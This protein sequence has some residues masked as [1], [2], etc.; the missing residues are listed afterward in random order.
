MNSKR[1]PSAAPPHHR[2]LLLVVATCCNM[3][4]A[5]EHLKQ[6]FVHHHQMLL[7]RSPLQPLLLKCELKVR[8]DALPRDN[9]P[10]TFSTLL[11][12]LA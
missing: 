3:R 6:C 9:M 7:M 11:G 5:S 8:P 4:V 2:V 10:L 12:G 1:G